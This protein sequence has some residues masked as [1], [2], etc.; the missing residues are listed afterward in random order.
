MYS[1]NIPCRVDG[2]GIG[3]HFSGGGT[4]CDMYV[5]DNVV[6][7]QQQYY[8]RKKP[9]QAIA[10]HTTKTPRKKTRGRRRIVKKDKDVIRFGGDATRK[11]ADCIMRHKSFIPLTKERTLARLVPN[12]ISRGS[13]RLRRGI[14]VP[15]I[16]MYAYLL[17]PH[18]THRNT[19]THTYT[20]A[21]TL[22]ERRFTVG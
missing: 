8:P 13:K 17:P 14:G 12:D 7:Y 1:L 20:L 18:I 19:R 16:Y 9:S 3:A 11:K 6:Q 10:E 21:Q 5:Y 22:Q 15:M 4:H 2:E